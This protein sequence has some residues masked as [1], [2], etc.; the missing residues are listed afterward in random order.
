MSEKTVF[1]FI[2]MAVF[3]ITVMGCGKE[4]ITCS[5]I[6]A[7][8]ERIEKID[9]IVNAAFVDMGHSGGDMSLKKGRPYELYL[10]NN[11]GK[12]EMFMYYVSFNKSK[13]GIVVEIKNA[14]AGSDPDRLEKINEYLLEITGKIKNMLETVHIEATIE[15]ESHSEIIK[16]C[17]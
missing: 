1:S 3:I 9:R 15:T 17:I 10:P 14:I 4:T 13:K 16:A 5:T 2:A 11:F 8:N 7:K 6:K 12:K